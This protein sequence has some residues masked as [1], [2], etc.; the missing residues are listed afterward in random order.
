MKPLRFFV[1]F[2]LIVVLG[3]TALATSAALLV[4]A[5]SSL[6][7][8]VSVRPLEVRLLAQPQRSYVFDRNGNLMT[9]LFHQD[10]A[11]VRLEDVPQVVIDAVLSIEDRKF[12]EHNGVDIEGIFRAARTNADS[13]QIQQGGSTITQQLLKN[14]IDLG[15]ERTTKLKLQEAIT[16]VRLEGELTKNQ[17]LEDY[18]NLVPFG[19]NAY[20]IEVAAERYFNKTMYQL[21]LPE[22]ALLAG[23]L[24]A[25]SALDPIA[26]PGKAAWRR[27]VVLQ[28]M[29][30]TH[31]ITQ[32]QADEAN[33]A[34]LPTTTYYPEPSQR[35]YYIDAMIGSLLEPK[36]ND[37][38]DPANVLGRD[39]HERLR[40]LRT[41][42]LRIYTNY[43]PA[44][45][46]LA[47]LAISDVIPTNQD[48]FTAAL[49]S[50]DNSDGAVRAVAF[51][52]GYDASQFDPAV[53]GPGRQ[54]GSSFKTITLATALSNGYSPD[55]RVDG[56]SLHWKLGPGDDYYN[57]SGDCHGGDPTLTEAIAISDNCAFVRTELSLGPGNY[58]QDGVN[59][60]IDM[61]SRMGIDTSNFQPVV[62][63]TLGYQRRAP[64][65]DGAGLLG[66]R[67][68]RHPVS[69]DVRVEDRRPER[70]G[71]VRDA[72]ERPAHPERAGC[73]L[74]DA[75][76]DRGAEERNG[77]GSHHRP[78]RGGQDG[79]DR[80]EPGCVVHRVHAA[81]HDCGVDGR[82]QCRD[83][84]DERRRHLRVRRDVP[85]RHL[86]R[87]HEGRA[88]G[89]PGGEVHSAQGGPVARAPADRRARAV[90]L[91]VSQLELR[92]HRD[93]TGD[94]PGHESEHAHDAADRGAD[95]LAARDRAAPA[96]TQESRQ[97]PAT[98]SAGAESLT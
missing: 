23:L 44:Q 63:T 54:P 74:G 11:P 26:H 94:G 59:K 71:P 68:G 39:E 37:P 50:I 92:L 85:G 30:Q 75:D 97:E 15:K 80:P 31:K 91:L 48:Q 77:V 28:V 40:K 25:P 95:D 82:P 41:G 67:V 73:S 45:Q 16:A 58:G 76:A 84:D 78:P 61:A 56:Y 89:P 18:L 79:H 52:R 9:T 83:P 7:K 86:G 96:A 29:V 22:A 46:Y 8:A 4:P 32:A 36:S 55:D 69:R 60:V 2:T 35:S 87:V 14:T 34:P 98:A 70:Q 21:T 27:G 66:D 13:G 42:G 38:A 3:A 53:D 64:V 65:G 49:V 10:R 81:D 17:I 90:Q 88:Q 1:N 72:D 93:D 12:Y 62:S 47:Q 20:G 19:H 57:L 6:K 43:D 5:G 33:S 51:G 24:Q